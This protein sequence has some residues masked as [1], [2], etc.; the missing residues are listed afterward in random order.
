MSILN[1]L[2]ARPPV[3]LGL[4]ALSFLLLGLFAGGLG[5]GGGGDGAE[6]V[7]RPSAMPVAVSLSENVLPAVESRWAS[8]TGRRPKSNTQLLEKKVSEWK[9][10][11]IVEPLTDEQ[12]Y[13][14]LLEAGSDELKRVYLSESFGEGWVLQHLLSSSVILIKD[15]EEIELSLY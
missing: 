6:D 14:L 3:S 8:R 12:R 4:G 2:A 11:G 7:W 15:S 10:L 1:W 13:A 5:A 9:L